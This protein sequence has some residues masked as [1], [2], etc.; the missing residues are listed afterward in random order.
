MSSSCLVCRG[1]ASVGL[2][3]KPCAAAI[4]DVPELGP[5][6]LERGGELADAALLD[7]WGRAHRLAPVTEI[8]RDPTGGGFLVIHHGSVSRSHARIECTGD[9]PVLRDRGSTNGTV[10]GERAITGEVELGSGDRIR[11]GSVGLYFVSPVKLDLAAAARDLNVPTARLAEAEITGVGFPKASIDVVEATG[12]GGG[13][14]VVDHRSVRLPLAQIQLAQLLTGRMRADAGKPMALR[15][16]V[17]SSE[18]LAGIS[19]DT[20]H[21]GDDHVKQLV[22]RLR[23]SLEKA[24]IGDVIESSQGFGYRLRLMPA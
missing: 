4:A 6:H 5:D 17:H 24:G 21:P 2:L 19:W 22:R 11:F 20:A 15:G 7:A 12:G 1:R 23:R 18:I 13:L 14:L 10:V 16:Y 9:R 3:C 8:G